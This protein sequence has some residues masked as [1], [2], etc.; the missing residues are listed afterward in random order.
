MYLS[1]LFSDVGIQELIYWNK[2]VTLLLMYSY[3]ISTYPI[4]WIWIFNTYI[5]KCN[6][7]IINT[8]VNH[9]IFV[10]IIHV[11]YHFYYLY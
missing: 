2:S 11:I 7:Y 4:I 8:N 10:Y 6:Y 9:N 5:I 1:I 3:K